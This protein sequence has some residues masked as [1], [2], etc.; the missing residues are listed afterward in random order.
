MDAITAVGDNDTSTDWELKP[1]LHEARLPEDA[2]SLKAVLRSALA[3]DFIR[4]FN[5]ADQKAIRAQAAYFRYGRWEVLAVT[6]AI[7]LGAFLLLLPDPET[8]AGA[9][10]KT[11]PLWRAFFAAYGTPILEGLFWAQVGAVAVAAMATA[12]M[13]AQVP[14]KEWMAQRTRAETARLEYFAYICNPARAKETAGTGGLPLLPLQLEYFRRYQLDVQLNYYAGRGEQHRKAAARFLTRGA[15]AAGAAALAA[16]LLPN[17]I[18]Q[19][20]LFSETRI[21]AFLLIAGPVL[22]NAQENLKLLHED[23]RNALR[24]ANTADQLNSVKA[25]ALGPAR[26]AA[27]AGHPEPVSALVAEVNGMVSQEHAQWTSAREMRMDT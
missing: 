23:Q 21:A 7:L 19:T 9:D 1:E 14:Y 12:V 13:R 5:D 8:L 3:L 24:Y 2:A 11:S 25:R 17:L 27:A 26:E 10:P 16:T 20:E 6:T 15:L 18:A 22:Y 4:R